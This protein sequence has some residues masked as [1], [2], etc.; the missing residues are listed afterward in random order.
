MF[1]AV[2]PLPVQA[3]ESCIVVHPCVKACIQHRSRL[4]WPVRERLD[5]CTEKGSKKG[6]YWVGV[7]AL[8][9]SNCNLMLHVASSANERGSVW[10]PHKCATCNPCTTVRT[11]TAMRPYTVTC[12]YFE[13]VGCKCY[14]P[15]YQMTVPVAVPQL[16][17]LGTGFPTRQDP[18]LDC[19]RI[20]LYVVLSAL[21]F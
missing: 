20:V 8:M 2:Q 19:R 10:S 12:G 15:L 14:Q 21:F 1:L 3:F 5:L 17:F 7:P 6:I 11:S 18:F 4:F 13:K 9:H 16:R